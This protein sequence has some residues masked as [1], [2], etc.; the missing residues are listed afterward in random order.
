MNSK[1]SSTGSLK[2][3]ENKAPTGRRP[4]QTPAHHNPPHGKAA[5]L[6]K[7]VGIGEAHTPKS[8]D[9]FVFYSSPLLALVC[10]PETP[11]ATFTLAVAAEETGVH[12][13]LLLYYCRLGLLGPARARR[14]VQPTFDGAALEEISRIEHYR[15]H[16]GVQRRALPLVCALWREGERRH[17]QLRFLEP[18]SGYAYSS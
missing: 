7:T 14:G 9:G 2:R 4:A 17:I 13:E 8:A 5:S 6:P 18:T 10:L 12:P 1:G 16:L 11:P 15:R 3:V